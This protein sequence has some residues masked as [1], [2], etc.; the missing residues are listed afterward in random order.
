VTAYA[1]IPALGGECLDDFDRLCEDDGLQE[2][3][4]HEAPSPETARN[5]LYQFHD[6]SKQVL[7]A[8]QMSYI[9]EDGAPLR[10]LAQLNQEMVQDVG[11]RWV[12]GAGGRRRPL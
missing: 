3:L 10:A 2:M 5:F 11:R 6:E 8:G 4:G 12:F 1:G 7:A 9:A